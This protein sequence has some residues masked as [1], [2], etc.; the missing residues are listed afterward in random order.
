MIQKNIRFMPE[1]PRT[2]PERR[3]TFS[4]KV[5]D[6]GIARQNRKQCAKAVVLRAQV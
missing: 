6:D 3:Q 1:I 4:M 2:V 5:L